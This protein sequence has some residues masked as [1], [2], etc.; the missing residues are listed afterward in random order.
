[1]S[2]P[3]PAVD[4]P[5][6]DIL[7]VGHGSCVVV[8][9]GGEV[10]LID[11]GP[12]GAILEYLRIEGITHINT[13]IISHADADHIGG[14]SAILG[15]KELRVDR[16]VWN[17]D[18]LKQSTLWK[19]LVYQLADLQ[20]QGRAAAEQNAHDGLCLKVGN[21]QDVEVR[22]LAPGLILRQLGAGSSLQDGR[23]ISSNAVSVVA[24]VVVAGEPLLLVPGDLDSLGYELL[25]KSSY[26]SRVKAKYMVLPHHGGLLGTP[27]QT[28][29]TITSFVTA[30]GPELVFISN[31]RGKFNNPRQDVI[32]AVRSA[33]A[34]VPIVCT[35]IAENCAV[36]ELVQLTVEEPYSVG[37]TRGYSCQGTTRLSIGNGIDAPLNRS[38]HLAFLASAVPGRICAS[39]SALT[40]QD[41]PP[42]S[43]S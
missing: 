13:I 39:S 28:S 5:I 37:W 19:N 30:V 10:L 42:E 36:K 7:D 11:A 3:S 29:E 14:V 32:N 21:M 4:S 43:V 15:Q 23:S 18:S 27:A 6:V 41:Q 1:M 12:G 22:I 33:G 40:E 2:A 16:I 38:R 8:R 34:S 25:A 35:Q 17:G 24:Q 26:G 31:G 20:D 9:S